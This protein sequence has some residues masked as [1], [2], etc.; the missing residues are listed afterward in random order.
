[1]IVARRLIRDRRRAL[2]WWA[3]GVVALV[4]FT[5]ALYPSVRDEA[6]FDDL[7]EDLP[8]AIRGA[9][10][11]DAG[12]PL[13]SGPGYLQGRLFATLVPLVLV[14]F[15]IGAGA[16]AIGGSEQSGTLEPLLANPISR[17]RV[18][19]ERYGA[20]VAQLVAVTA[21]LTVAVVALAAPVGALDGVSAAGLLAACAGVFG[22]ALLH[23][24]LA[25]AVGAA[26]GR[27]TTA[28]AVATVVAVAG[29]LLQSLIGLTDVLEPLRFITPWHW[30][31]D[32]NM[33]AEG[34][35][36]IPLVAPV[37]ISA[38]LLAVGW[39]AFGRRDL[40]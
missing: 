1:M 4:A 28:V 6:S 35:S 5:V 25:F 34:S 8:E 7:V 30:Y 20:T 12:V 15:G 32:R 23:G 14:I 22:L 31:L 16:Q 19:L 38:G 21:I 11:Y 39:A 2:L 37:L 3:V 24:T 27:R 36:W 17:T 26:S 13:T 29:Y 10:G 40:R 33:L 9:I 18:L